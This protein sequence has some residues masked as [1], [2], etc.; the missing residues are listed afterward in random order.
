MLK[1][2]LI[3]LAGLLVVFLI[4]VA[5][6]P[7]SFSV[8]RSTTIAAPAAAVFPHVN[9][10]HAWTDWS[11]WEK[12]DPAL[13]RTYEGAASGTGAIYKWSSEVNGVGAGMMTLTDSHPSELIQIKLDFFKPFEA[14]NAVEF[15]FKP[16][17]DKTVVTWKM[18]GA[19][20]FVGKAMCLFMN[21]DK[22][23]GGDFEKGLASLKT[24]SETAKEKA[25]E[26]V[27]TPAPPKAKG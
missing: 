13:K 14:S 22:M 24:V 16:D 3:G 25:H 11:P 6:Q 23:V 27:E 2:V 10:F 7:N 8:M 4:V 20:N 12:L 1:K 5:L 19:S 9:D 21:M 18:S 15:A 26:A 17:G